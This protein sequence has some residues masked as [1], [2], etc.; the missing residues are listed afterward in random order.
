MTQSHERPEVEVEL[1]SKVL[2]RYNIK[3]ATVVNDMSE[4][5]TT[6]Y[7]YEELEFDKTVAKEIRDARAAK[8]EVTAKK[9]EAQEYLNS[10]DWYA[11]RCA[12]QGVAIP[13]EVS[14]KRQ[15]CRELL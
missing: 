12:D 6:V 3:E 7:T 8:A 11:A 13:E 2:V 14:K 9:N 5:E 10:T 4:E 1:G 15:E